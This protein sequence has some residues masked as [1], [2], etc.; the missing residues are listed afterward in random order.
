[1]TKISKR[2]VLLAALITITACFCTNAAADA[3][4][5][6]AKEIPET[7]QFSVFATGDIHGRA[8]AYNYETT[9][10]ELNQGLSKISTLLSKARKDLPGDNSILVDAGDFLYD[11]S[12]NYFYNNHPETIQPVLQVMNAME[13]DCITLGNHELDYPIE[14]LMDQLKA[15]NLYDKVIVSNLIHTD[16]TENVF[17]PSA[18][19]TKE[20]VTAKGNT[21]KLRI[22]VVGATRQ[23][24]STRRQYYGFFTGNDIYKSVLAEAKRLKDENAADLVIAVIHGGI[25]VLSGSNTSTHPGARLAKSDY[26]DGV[27]TSHT[28]E[29]FPS[30]NGTYSDPIYKDIID[31]KNGLVY[32]T[33]VVGTGSNAATLGILNFTLVVNNDGTYSVES[34][35]SSV[36]K[37]DKKTSESKVHNKIY[38]KYMNMMFEAQDKTEYPIAEGQVYT[39]L[40]CFIQDN[41]LFQLY[42]NAKIQFGRNYINENLPEYKNLPVITCTSNILDSTDSDIVITGAFN[43]N[44]VAQIIAEQSITRDSGY[45]HIFKITGK[46]LR[47]WL[48]YNAGIYATA[49]LYT[50]EELLPDYY[51]KAPKVVPLLQ[52]EYYDNHNKFYIFDG[53]NYVIDIS[54]KARYRSNGKMI[55]SSYKRISS[56]TYNGVEVTDKQEFIIVTDAFDIRYSF[57]PQD[58][59]SVYKKNPWVNGKEVFI[60]YLKQ[61]SLTG[62]IK[63]KA[64]NNWRIVAPGGYQFAVGMPYYV[65]DY[66]EPK[67]WFT[68]YAAGYKKAKRY[69][70]YYKGSFKKSSVLKQGLNVILSVSTASHTSLPVEVTV[71]AS[72][73]PTANISEIKYIKGIQKDVKDSKWSKAQDIDNNKFIVLE[74]DSYTVRVKDSLGNVSINVITVNNIDL[75]LLEAPICDNFTNRIENLTGK[76]LPFATV[77]A[78]LSD[79]TIFTATANETGSFLITLPYQKAYETFLVYAEL[80]DIKSKEQQVLVRR[81]GPD[82][83]VVISDISKAVNTFSGFV[84]PYSVV[85]MRYG[86]T[87][88]VN[89]GDVEHY[90]ACDFYKSTYTIVETDITIEVLG[91]IAYFTAILPRYIPL[92]KTVW[93]YSLDKN[94]KSSKGRDLLIGS[95]TAEEE[96]IVVPDITE[97]VETEIETEAE[98][99]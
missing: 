18:I 63:V 89:Y 25:G 97:N 86:N 13:Y 23:A 48:E 6:Y 67:E 78:I 61:L 99:E 8:T 19:I 75:T 95:V 27:V 56:L 54:Q 12:T 68:S 96:I 58:S 42:N 31:E 62:P 83:P 2:K 36:K 64:D 1:M 14:Y 98:T 10:P 72:T 41:D 26:I 9:L 51:K 21:V 85:Y 46:E 94:N 4:N 79:N 50:F 47:E 73:D 24:L 30:N 17:A 60:N 38:E 53:I 84:D 15:S 44:N 66:I 76:T 37:P 52:S 33:P 11:Y 16:S 74:N 93:I 32:K 69:P 3:V 57:M 29:V 92:S 90:M 71:T 43:E 81:T 39:N 91:D 87:V 5:T 22:G 34:S 40:D 55:A 77:Y 82:M 49:G 28:H 7:V 45:L 20:V 70:V 59:Q 35:N 65:R 88:Y 80:N